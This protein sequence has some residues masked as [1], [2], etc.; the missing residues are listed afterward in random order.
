MCS[1][2][3]V[4]DVDHAFFSFD[5]LLVS[6]FFFS[7]SFP[8][9]LCICFNF[10]FCSKHSTIIVV[11][12]SYSH[13]P[14]C[15]K[16]IL[17]FISKSAIVI[18]ATGVVVVVALHLPWH[19]FCVRLC[20]VIIRSNG[21]WKVFFVRRRLF[22]F[23]AFV[24]YSSHRL[25]RSNQQFF[26]FLS[27]MSF[28]YKKSV[29]NLRFPFNINIVRFCHVYHGFGIPANTRTNRCILLFFLFSLSF[30]HPCAIFLFISS[31][32]RHRWT[33]ACSHV[34]V[35]KYEKKNRLY[36]FNSAK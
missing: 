15:R 33:Y 32:V 28:L 29:C 5:F 13:T 26:F 9:F 19:W 10:D 24:L 20:F 18:I 31:S 21:V 16:L 7:L 25:A 35:V 23:L 11:I 30:L 14:H 36:M 27:L 8:L 2:Y 34:N 3:V 6:C 22:L 4:D 1:I 17:V 12:L